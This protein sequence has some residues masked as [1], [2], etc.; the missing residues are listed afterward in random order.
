MKPRTAF[1]SDSTSESWDYSRVPTSTLLWAMGI[2][3]RDLLH[4]RQALYQPQPEIVRFQTFVLQNENPIAIK[5]L[6][7]SMGFYH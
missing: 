1:S 7:F 6:A 4:V 2:E 5:L 3:P